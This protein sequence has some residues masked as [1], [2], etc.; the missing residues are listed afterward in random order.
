MAQEMLPPKYKKIVLIGALA[1]IAVLWYMAW[2]EAKYRPASE[3][4][5]QNNAQ[6]SAA[7]PPKIETNKEPD[8]EKTGTVVF[9]VPGLKPN[10]AY[11]EFEEPGSPALNTELVFDL[12]SLCVTPQDVPVFCSSLDSEPDT[13]YREKRVSVQGVSREDGSVLVKRISLAK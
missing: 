7:K 4:A 12:Y 5:K 10:A 9:N 2:H 1:V 8:F 11:L 6:I 13:Q 3:N